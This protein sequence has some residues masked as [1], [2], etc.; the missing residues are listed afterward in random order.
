MN[1]IK[2]IIFGLEFAQI[3]WV[4]PNIQAAGHQPEGWTIINKWRKQSEVERTKP[5]IS[6]GLSLLCVIPLG[7]RVTPTTQCLTLVRLGN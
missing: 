7:S 1:R 4:V 5:Q 3:G 6:L 2:N